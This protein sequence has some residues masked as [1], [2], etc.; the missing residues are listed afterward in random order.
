MKFL[1]FNNKTF[2][3]LNKIEFSNYRPIRYIRETR[4]SEF[5]KI[6]IETSNS[7]LEKE[8]SLSFDIGVIKATNDIIPH[9][10]CVQLNNRL[11]EIFNVYPDFNTIHVEQILSPFIEERGSLEDDTH[12]ILKLNDEYSE[13][14]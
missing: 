9:K 3:V 8:D 12:H 1:S 4:E 6:H 14:S 7:T 13:R 2:R 11:L 10:L 5:Y